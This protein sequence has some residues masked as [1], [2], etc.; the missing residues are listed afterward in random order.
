MATCNKLKN[1][2][3]FFLILV[4]IAG[5]NVFYQLTSPFIMND[6]TRH[7]ESLKKNYEAANNS[8]KQ[9]KIK[10]NLNKVKEFDEINE[11]YCNPK[12]K[13][14]NITCLEKLSEFDE[15]I[16]KIEEKITD[17][18]QKCIRRD[19]K[20]LTIYHHTF[21]QLNE[22]KSE[23]SQFYRRTIFL[24]LMSYLTT[25]NLC[26]T[27]FIFWKLKEFPQE[28]EKEIRKS[29]EYFIEQGNLEIKLFDLKE[30]CANS[31][32][33]FKNTYVCNPSNNDNLASQHLI[34]LSDFVRFIV[35]DV[36]GGIYTG[37]KYY[38]VLKIF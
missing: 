25:Q 12:T 4:G 26:C 11:K 27:K 17:K 19:N 22:I 6:N 14:L 20:I 32:S 7:I 38:L 21:W 36:Y 3:I 29:F 5:I 23:T 2:A 15:K 31:Q 1:K 33:S 34:S 30:L 35:L 16:S 18:C 10:M 28:I 24:N 13:E 8:F 9:T 37:L